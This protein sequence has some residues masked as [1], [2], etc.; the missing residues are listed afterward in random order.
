MAIIGSQKL[1]K[2]IAD[3]REKA[4]QSG[5]GTVK[6]TSPLVNP[7]SKSPSSSPQTLT[8]QPAHSGKRL[9]AFLKQEFPHHSRS[10][11]QRWIAEG[12]V[13]VNNQSRPKDY[14]L[15]PGDVIAISFPEEIPLH[16]VQP[17]AIPLTIL[18]E[19]EDLAVVVKP[20]GMLVHPTQNIHSGT[21]VNAL[22]HHYGS[23]PCE[24]GEEKYRAGI[25]HRLDKDTEGLMLIARSL[26]AFRILREHFKRHEILRE[27]L[28]LCWGKTPPEG[29]IEK[30]LGRDKKIRI[31]ISP[32]TKKPREAKTQF[33]T[34]KHLDNF[35]LVRIQPHTGRTHQIRSHFYT[36][37]FPLVGDPLYTTR[38]TRRLQKKYP[39]IPTGQLLQAYL[40]A[41]QHPVKEKIFS[42]S[43]PLSPAISQFLQLVSTR[44]NSPLHPKPQSR[45]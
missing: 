1:T 8:A 33:F 31:R 9:D 43:A 28:A 10:Q 17:E 7:R 19:D 3:G 16:D 30:P 12:R 37:G 2:N 41:F 20:R 18:Y 40:I 11:I 26:P 25:V 22:L 15:R 4:Q 5:S 29:I 6:E 14:R 21:L 35:S 39:F 13:L 38:T 45:T 36:L 27:Y 24:I 42:F 23:L 32:R 44:S 34:L